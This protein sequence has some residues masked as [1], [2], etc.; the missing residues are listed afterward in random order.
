MYENRSLEK[1][2]LTYLEVLENTDFEY[3]RNAFRIQRRSFA[4]MTGYVEQLMK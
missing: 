3:I 1:E 2:V 4:N